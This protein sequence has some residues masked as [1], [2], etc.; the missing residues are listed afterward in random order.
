MCSDISVLYLP[1]SCGYGVA[2]IDG[3]DWLHQ[4]GDEQV[5]EAEV[6]QQH[7]RRRVLQLLVV[8]GGQLDE[9]HDRV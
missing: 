2:S 4:E 6:D 1:V 9:D 3:R 7:V 5:G 8:P